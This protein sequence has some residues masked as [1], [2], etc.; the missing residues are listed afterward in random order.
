MKYEDQIKGMQ[1]QGSAYFNI[2]HMPENARHSFLVGVKQMME[3]YQGQFEFWKDAWKNRDISAEKIVNAGER[4]RF[5]KE[6]C[7]GDVDH[8]LW[9]D[10][11]QRIDSGDTNYLNALERAEHLDYISQDIPQQKH[12][13]TRRSMKKLGL[14]EGEPNFDQ[15]AR[16]E[17]DRRVE[18]SK[19]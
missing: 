12:V 10:R 14:L 9:A 5:M 18:L 8:H 6:K 17:F 16:A 7:S 1:V 4:L 15:A 11:W 2:L 19:P 13:S 3:D